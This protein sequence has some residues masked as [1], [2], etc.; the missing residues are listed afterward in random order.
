MI[1]RYQP[2]PLPPAD[3]LQDFP[4]LHPVVATV[5]Y[6]LNIRTAEA[7]DHYLHPL[8]ERDQHDPFLFTDMQKVVERIVTARDA[9]QS[10]LVYGDYDADG[11]CSTV[12]LYTALQEIGIKKL[13]M[14]LP[15]RDTEGY[16][17]NAAAVE[18]FHTEGIHLIITVDC[19]I[20]NA[21]EVARAAEL[22]MDVIVTDHHVEPP[23]LPEAAFAI[24]N[25]QVKRCG[26]PWPMLA[27]VGVAFK[28]AQAL[29]QHLHLE[30]RFE[31]WLLD[32]VAISTVTDCMPLQD[33][34]RTFVKYGLVVLNKTK[35]L[36]LQQL[37]AATHK[38]GTAVTTTGI[39]YR[40]GPWINAA[41]RID[42]ANVAV[43]LLLA[44][45]VEQAASD[46]AA[47]G[48][49]NT[50]RQ[51]QT[52]VMF[53][54]ARL[55]AAAQTDQPVLFTYGEAWPL[56][57]VGL[58]AGKLVSEFHKPAFVM[59]LNKNRVFGSG[60]SVAGVNLI[61]TLQQM[62]DCFDRYG[63]H[64]MACGFSLEDNV[65]RTQFAKKFVTTVQSQLDSL[66]TE[67]SIPVAAELRVADVNWTLV[68]QLEQMQPW[69]EGNLE[70]LFLFQ[71][72]PVKDFQTVGATNTHLR[73]VLSEGAQS[74]KA[75]AFGFGK[76]ADTLKL[77]DTV[78]LVGK[79]GVNEWNDKRDIQLMVEDWL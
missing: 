58:V 60:R 21:V 59:T 6:H 10:V 65:T 61:K 15:H 5:L 57:L 51:E 31:K 7:I 14:Y 78:T 11:V 25:P 64:A 13:S 56:G 48:K 44:D 12:L 71:N 22:G 69:G 19:G 55:Q 74:L 18:R 20:S 24:I 2:Q 43:Q 75:I 30:E 52:E 28:V 76:K 45:N 35:R 66:P 67:H 62:S 41:G 37:I 27:G 23:Q 49:T 8:Y 36:G 68:E 9:D 40:L 34:N 46:V 54:A 47:L 29:R 33:E 16:G 26:Y 4:E 39:S 53:Q 70:P 79:I 73:L 1:K 42:H 32:L 3:W 17:L 72:V 38:P 77:G 50:S 63:G